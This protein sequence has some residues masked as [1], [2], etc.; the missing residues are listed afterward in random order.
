MRKITES[1]YNYKGY[2]IK[3]R[4]VELNGFWYYIIKQIP[5]DKSPNGIKNIYLRQKGWNFIKPN[6]LLEKAKSYI[7]DFPTE[8]ETKFNKLTNEYISNTN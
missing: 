3:L 4:A 6:D 8:L 7:D 2:I 5:N 1:F